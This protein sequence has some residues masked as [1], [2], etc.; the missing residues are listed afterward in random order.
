MT[1]KPQ[2]KITSRKQNINKQEKNKTPTHSNF[3]I[4]LNLNQQYHKDEHKANIDND[5]EIFDGLLVEFLN[6]IEGYVRLPEDIA[7][8]DDNIKDVSADYVVEVGNIKKQIHAHIM[9]KFKHFTR[10]QLNFGK[11]K[12][13]FKKKLGLKNVYMQAKLLRPSASENVIDYLD[14]MT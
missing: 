5:M 2:I 14:K 6:H 11:I 4:T 1:S 13:F 7:Y 3:L 9:L 12:E 10:I 8:N